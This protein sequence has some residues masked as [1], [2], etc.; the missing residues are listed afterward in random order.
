MDWERLDDSVAAHLS[1][2]AFQL[3]PDGRVWTAV[4]PT[5]GHGMAVRL[6]RLI[7]YNQRMWHWAHTEDAKNKESAPEPTL[8][9]GE[10]EAYEQAVESAEDEAA[11][12]AEALG[13]KL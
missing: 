10:E 2:L 1:A 5:R 9:P 12:T 4:E 6:L 13:I 8:L 7:E 3:P 11:K